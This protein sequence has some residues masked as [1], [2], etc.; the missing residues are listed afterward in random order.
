MG[1]TTMLCKQ[2]RKAG[3]PPIMDIASKAFLYE[4]PRR[5]LPGMTHA[6]GCMGTAGAC[7][8]PLAEANDDFES[9][10]LVASTACADDS[11]GCQECQR[12]WSWNNG[13]VERLACVASH[14]A[15]CNTDLPCKTSS[16]G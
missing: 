2:E 5:E 10:T 4:R 9:A 7:C 11:S 8:L 1:K 14:G 6:P 16:E 13:E 15:W 12:T 3:V